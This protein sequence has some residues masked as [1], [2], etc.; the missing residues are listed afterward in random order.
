[1]FIS[2]TQVSSAFF[3]G[4]L[5][6]ARTRDERGFE[7][8]V[9]ITRGDETLET[10]NTDYDGTTGNLLSRRRNNGALEE[11]GYDNLDRLLSVKSGTDESM[12]VSYA[13][14]GNILFKTGVGNFY[15]DKNTRPHAVAEVENADGSI[16][17]DALNTSFNNFGKIQ[18]I[19]D[20][21]KGL[22]MDFGYGPDRQRWYSELLSNGKVSRTTVYAGEY[23]K[24]TENGITR[25]FYYLDGNTIVVRQNG[26]TGYYLAFTD[27]LGSILSAMDENGRKVFDASYDAWGRQTVTLNT[28]GLH[29]GYTGHEM[30]NEFDII[31]MNGRLYDPVLG[32]FLSPDNYVQAPES[33]QSFNRYSYCMNNP[34]KYTDPSGDLW[35]LIIGAAIGGFFNWVSHGFQ[36]NAKGLG[37]FAV[38]AAAGAAGAGLASGVSVAMAGGSFWAGAAGMANGVA[39]T[40]F[41]AGAASG[42]SA[43]FASGFFTGAGNS[44][45][46]GNSF[47]DGILTGMLH[48]GGG[49]LG[50]GFIGGVMGG[51]D[52]VNKGTNF[53]TGTA[54]IELNGAYKCCNCFSPNFELGEGTITGKYVGKYE[55]V[56]VFETKKLGSIIIPKPDG[57]FHYKAVTIPERGIIA[58]EGSFSSGKRFGVALMQHEFGHIL[59]YRNIG[60][61]AYWRIIA[62]ESLASATLNPSAH[63][64]F[65]TETWAN[66]LSKGYFGR[67]WIGGDGYPTKNIS[68]L[69]L[70]R[71]KV[72]QTVMIIRNPLGF[73]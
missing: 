34:L 4:K 39:S 15:Y 54:K 21:G 31:N 48:G 3:M 2:M 60:S 18:L 22:R 25:E 38:G 70:I 41:F 57:Y 40:G 52:A 14:N 44:W 37:Y 29:R 68:I 9:R 1:M 16:P 46:E 32:R 6:S 30:L 35:N 58:A 11:F 65:W 28:I 12:R 42:A 33:S 8:S 62:P 69:N 72:A 27:N 7:S 53:W 64:R 24:T 66:Y 10:F 55:G 45:V 61:S 20:V 17:G 49:A 63:Y 51:F 59:Q 43:G 73:L 36:F 50:G 56:N 19:E 71:I 47:G 67:N 13:P 23:E 26:I 5:M